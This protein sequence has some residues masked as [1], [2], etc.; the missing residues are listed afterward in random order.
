MTLANIF[1]FALVLHAGVTVALVW[2]IFG[3]KQRLLALELQR[4]TTASNFVKAFTK[5]GELQKQSPTVLAAKVEELSEAVERLR[6]T[7]QRFAGRIDQKLGAQ[8]PGSGLNLDVD[9]DEFA[10][11]LALQSAPPGRPNGG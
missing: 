5:L 9:D 1:G 4:S 6:L 2:T 11:F 3:L 7:H 8:R 10:G